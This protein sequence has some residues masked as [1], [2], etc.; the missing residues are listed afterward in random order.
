MYNQ[1]AGPWES[2][3]PSA[4]FWAGRPSAA[5]S[6]GSLKEGQSA[7]GTW[8]ALS[9]TK[10]DK[11]ALKPLPGSRTSSSST[12]SALAWL[13]HLGQ[14]HTSTLGSSLLEQDQTGYPAYYRM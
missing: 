4:A 1:R 5:S 14:G 6:L 10:V 9:Q 11:T 8:G 7:Q 3:A 13:W 12:G 2:L